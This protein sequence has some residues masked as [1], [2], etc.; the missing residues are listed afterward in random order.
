MNREN[1]NRR[2]VVTGVGLVSHEAATS[3]ELFENVLAGR[4]NPDIRPFHS[5]PGFPPLELPVCAVAE[6][7]EKPATPVP[8]RGESRLDR[9]VRLGLVAASRAWNVAGLAASPAIDPSR[10]AAVAGSSRGTIG[11]WSEACALL[12]SGKKVPPSLSANSTFASLHGSLCACFGIEGP[13]FTVSTACA[14]GGHAIA[15]AADLLRSGAASVALCGGAD[16]GLHHSLALN[17]HA[18]GILDPAMPPDAVCRPFDKTASGTILGEGACFLV[19]ESMEHAH[20][21]GAEPLAELLG[22]GMASDASRVR[23]EA[24]GARALGHAVRSALDRAGLPAGAVHYVNVHGTGTR[25]NDQIECGWLAEFNR[26]REN[27][28]P[29]LY[30]SSKA[31]MGHCLGASPALEAA[32]CIEALARRTA[33]PSA[34]LFTPREDAPTGLLKAPALLPED[35]VILSTSLSFWGAACALLFSTLAR[36]GTNSPAKVAD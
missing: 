8:M 10:V 31:V 24:A 35:A 13:A 9:S 20:R 34:N 7:L 3:A 36:T 19:L 32:L 1:P 16:A 33:P 14:S 30:S 29:V 17:F 18:T 25:A 21:R 2:I 26:S 27:T 5:A 28:P 23:P 12:S 11:K 22:W 4:A 15:L 6:S